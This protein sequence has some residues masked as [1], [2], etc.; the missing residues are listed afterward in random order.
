VVFR[1]K[2][3]VAFAPIVSSRLTPG[4]LARPVHG[5]CR[6]GYFARTAGRG[7][8]NKS[9]YD[10]IIIGGGPAGLS[11]ALILGRCRRRVLV[12]DTGHPRNAASRGLHGF[13]TRD[14]IRPERFLSTARKELE[15]YGVPILTREVHAV[16]PEGSGFAVTLAGGK[17]LLCRT[18]LL[19]TGVVDELPGIPG[20]R[21]MYGRS[22]FHCPYCDG[23]EV[24]DEPLAVYGGGI[25]A[26]RL[27][28]SL[29][30]WTS[31]VVLLSGGARLSREA[32]EKLSRNGVG[33]RREPVVRLEGRNGLLRRVLFASGE[34]L[35]RRAMFFRTGQHQRSALAEKLGCDFTRKGT[36]KTDRL[37]ATCIRGVYCAGDAS[38]DV[39]LVVVAAAEGAKAAFAIN[40]ALQRDE[41][42]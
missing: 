22:V 24:R 25:S 34:P 9:V 29:R 7:L 33:L 39:Q 14:G 26:V 19:A 5:A 17:R 16:K 28:L 32:R 36:V 37:S 21:E 35:L 27:A 10:A 2:E 42:T 23:W 3:S 18:L 6:R 40:H 1:S 12:C 31:D 11:A 30:T 15:P 8:K 20:A 13:L 38:E 41:I 4:A